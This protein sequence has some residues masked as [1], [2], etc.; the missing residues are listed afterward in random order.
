MRIDFTIPWRVAPKQSVRSRVAR[1][2]DGKAYVQTYQTNDIKENAETLAAL[3]APHCPPVPLEGPLSVWYTVRYAYRKSEPQKNRS[4]AM[5]K[6][7]RPDADQ[8]AKQLSD[9][10]E[11]VGFFGDDA[12]IAELSIV[13]LWDAVPSV[14]VLLEQT[15]CCFTSS[16]EVE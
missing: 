11:A 2:K 14:Q 16:A 3:V 4:A 10:L 15:R 13:K 6:H 12:Q 5:Y 9:V 8:L 7:T 1:T